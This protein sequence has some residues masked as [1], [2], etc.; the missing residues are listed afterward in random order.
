MNDFS[1]MYWRILNTEHHF[2]DSLLY[3]NKLKWFIFIFQIWSFNMVE[4][5][6]LKNTLFYNY[7][8]MAIYV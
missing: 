3:P 4:E 8:K 1:K 2:C 6:K 5:I 7:N